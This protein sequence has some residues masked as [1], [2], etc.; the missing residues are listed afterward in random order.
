MKKVSI[1]IVVGRVL[2]Y[3]YTAWTLIDTVCRKAEK[4]RTGYSREFEDVEY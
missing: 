1:A 2:N 3:L 4:Y